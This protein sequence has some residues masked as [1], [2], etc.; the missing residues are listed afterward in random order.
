[1]SF[2]STKK[3]H[4]FIRKSKSRLAKSCCIYANL[5]KVQNALGDKLFNT[6]TQAR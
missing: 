4:K 3:T 6:N 5:I 1:M 2:R